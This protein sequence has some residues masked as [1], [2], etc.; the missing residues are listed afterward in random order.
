[1]TRCSVRHATAR[2]EAA[3]HDIVI[4]REKARAEIND[5]ILTSA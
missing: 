2:F 1:M 3:I 4:A 5:P